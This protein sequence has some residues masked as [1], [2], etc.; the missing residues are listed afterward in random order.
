MGGQGG[1][2]QTNTN[3]QAQTNKH[4]QTNTNTFNSAKTSPSLTPLSLTSDLYTPGGAIS[5]EE[6]D[7]LTVVVEVQHVSIE[8]VSEADFGD[9]VGQEG[10]AD[11]GVNDLVFG[12][13]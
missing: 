6:E 2:K 7:N 5:N 3:K 10:G 12:H 13:S 11:V 9:G 1:N 4:K 8:T